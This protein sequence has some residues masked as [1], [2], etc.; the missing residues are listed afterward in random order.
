MFALWARSAPYGATASSTDKDDVHQCS[1]TLPNVSVKATHVSGGVYTLSATVSKG[2]HPLKT[3]NFKVDDQIVSSRE[4]SANGTY[5]YTH[6]FSSTG[7]HKVAAEVID[8]V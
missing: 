4:I 8:R 6:N 5:D 2:T 7:S 1:D 3:L